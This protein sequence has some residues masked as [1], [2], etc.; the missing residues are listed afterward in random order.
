MDEP[1]A[2]RAVEQ[3]NGLSLGWRVGTGRTGFLEGGPQR[4]SLRAVAHGR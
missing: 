2:G 1:L 3:L 4:R